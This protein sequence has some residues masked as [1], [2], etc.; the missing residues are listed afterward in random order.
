MKECQRRCGGKIKLVQ[1][2]TGKWHPVDLPLVKVPEGRV[3]Y[4]EDAAEWRI[5]DA[6]LR[7][8]SDGTI[9]PRCGRAWPVDGGAFMSHMDSCTKIARERQEER[10]RL[11]RDEDGDLI[12][13]YVWEP[14]RCRV[15]QLPMDE[16]LAA[17]EAWTC[18]PSCDPAHRPP[19]PDE[20]RRIT[21]KDR[22][23][24]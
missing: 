1:L 15:C 11:R 5:L 24:P 8:S 4:D 3:V 9:E 22:L 23:G 16:A 2:D 21:R 13:P 17:D 19:G 10:R 12:D 7:R 14:L 20:A 18:C 6:R